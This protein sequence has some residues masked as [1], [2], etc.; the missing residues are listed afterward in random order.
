MAALILALS[1]VFAETGRAAPGDLSDP[2]TVF[3]TCAGRFSAEMEHR[4]LVGRDPD[5]A[6]RHRGA[7]ID[8]LDA[9]V[10][11][12]DGRA[13]L[14]RRIEAK[15]AQATLLMRADFNVNAEDA[16]QARVL[17]DAALSR[18]AALIAG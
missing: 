6:A 1:P 12:V 4:W 2:V 10:P 17:A 15:H 13:V 7:M 16:R 3:A 14:A 5:R 11:N 9:V 8:L 18:C